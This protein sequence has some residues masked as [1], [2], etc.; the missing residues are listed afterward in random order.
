MTDP[1]YT[2]KEIIEL[3]FRNL[4]K[5]M[6]EI[7]DML[8]A[9]NTQFEMRFTAIEKDIDELRLD[10]ARYKLIWGIG[11]TVGA[12]LVAFFLNRIF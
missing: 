11:A 3:Q 12:S 8:K 10:N 6:T 7:K 2:V 1:T 4:S 5:E 9:Q